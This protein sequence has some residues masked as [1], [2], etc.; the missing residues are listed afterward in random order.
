M[1]F[2]S[3]K[4]ISIITPGIRTKESAAD[5]QKRTLD[6][7]SAIMLGANYLVVGRPITGATDISAAA[8]SMFEEATA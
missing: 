6:P 8:K 3:S 5:D 1:L 2:R 7:K 4:E